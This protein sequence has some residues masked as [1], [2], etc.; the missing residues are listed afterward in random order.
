MYLFFSL[1]MLA[2]LEFTKTTDQIL[3]VMLGLYLDSEA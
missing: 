3:N 1:D 2:V